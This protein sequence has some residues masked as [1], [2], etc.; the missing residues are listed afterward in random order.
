[1]G[2]EAQSTS[3]A[4]Q[5][6]LDAAAELFYEQGVRATGVD[7]VVETAGVSKATLYAH[8]SSKDDL[9]VA[10]LHELYR[11]WEE[12]L[13]KHSAEARTPIQQVQ[14][15]FDALAAWFDGAGHRGCPS[16]TTV[17]EFPDADHAV[18]QAAT[19]VQLAYRGYFAHIAGRAGSPTP[20][21]DA[22]RLLTLFDGATV[23]AVATSSR[24]PIAQARNMATE[25]ASRWPHEAS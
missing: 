7:A 1:M 6:L 24:D 5:R 14:A 9:V 19:E 22:D 25:L 12:V 15:V 3:T 10:Y 16:V 13:A 4:R 20:A 2:Q 11:R 23:A 21:Q 17:M 8:F 18:R